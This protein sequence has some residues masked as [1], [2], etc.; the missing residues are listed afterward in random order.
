MYNAQGYSRVL[1]GPVASSGQQIQRHCIVDGVY[2]VRP[3]SETVGWRPSFSCWYH[4]FN[5]YD[6]VLLVSTIG[7]Y[8]LRP[9]TSIADPL[10]H[11][12]ASRHYASRILCSWFCDNKCHQIWTSMVFAALVSGVTGRLPL[13]C[14]GSNQYATA[15]MTDMAFGGSTG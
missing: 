14:L 7:R 15:C 9:R 2:G 1:A 6:P 5:L 3:A 10:R 12:G 11:S 8:Y 13:L 4:A